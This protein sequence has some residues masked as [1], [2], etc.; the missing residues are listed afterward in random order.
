MNSP[1]PKAAKNGWYLPTTTW[2]EIL[3]AAAEVGRDITP[4]LL[5]VPQLASSELVARVGGPLYA[6]LGTHTVDT[7]H[8]LAGTCGGGARPARTAGVR[9]GT[10]EGLEGDPFQA[11][12]ARPVDRQPAR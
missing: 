1:P 6:Y 3:K 9:R 2:R 8:P 10:P 4:N 5:R 11:L 7:K 12:G